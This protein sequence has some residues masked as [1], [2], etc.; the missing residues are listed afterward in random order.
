MHIENKFGPGKIKFGVQD[1][2]DDNEMSENQDSQN[3][4]DEQKKREQF[5]DVRDFSITTTTISDLILRVL[6]E[7]ENSENA[8]DDSFFI[9]KILSNLGKLDNF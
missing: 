2:E 5:I 6:R 8:F 3:A 1:E 4:E 7:N 9:G